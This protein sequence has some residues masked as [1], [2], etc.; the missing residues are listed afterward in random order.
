MYWEDVPLDNSLSRD[1]FPNVKSLLFR[2]PWKVVDV[3]EKKKREKQR[4]K[5]DKDLCFGRQTLFACFSSYW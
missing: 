3:R 5:E 1:S 2:P 4:R